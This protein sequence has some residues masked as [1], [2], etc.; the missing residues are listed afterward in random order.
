MVVVISSAKMQLLH[1]F[2]AAARKQFLQR[3]T[4]FHEQ[5]LSASFTR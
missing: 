4:Q 1:E 5:R 3:L 2:L